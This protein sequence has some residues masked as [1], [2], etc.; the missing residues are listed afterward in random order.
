[1]VIQNISNSL[2][3]ILDG[4]QIENYNNYCIN[5]YKMIKFEIIFHRFE[6]FLFVY[7]RTITYTSLFENADIKIKTLFLR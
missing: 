3:Y 7:G 4:I 1:M 2:Q 5:S 6:R